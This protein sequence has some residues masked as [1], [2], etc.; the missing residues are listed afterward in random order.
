MDGKETG[1]K[2]LKNC[3]NDVVY[4]NPF[5]GIVNFCVFAKEGSPDGK[6]NLNPSCFNIVQDHP[7][8]SYGYSENIDL[9]NTPSTAK[10]WID[11]RELGDIRDEGKDKRTVNVYDNDRPN[12]I[13]RITNV[14]TGSQMFFPP[15]V[16]SSEAKI[17]NSSLY[18]TLNGRTNED[19]YKLFVENLG[20]DYNY[21]A[22]IAAP[23]FK[24]PY[25]VFSVDDKTIKTETEKENNY[26]YR[27]ILNNDLEFINFN[28]RVEDYFC[29]DTN[30]DGSKTYVHKPG[31]VGKRNGTFTKMVALWE[32]SGEFYIK[33]NVEYKLDVWVDDNVK[34]CNVEDCLKWTQHKAEVVSGAN[35]FHTGVKSGV[36][37]LDVPNDNDGESLSQEQK[38]DITKNINGDIYFTLKKSTPRVYDF[39]TPEEIEENHFPSISVELEDFSGLYRSLKLYFRVDDRN[40][41]VRV[42]EEKKKKKKK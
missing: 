12:I 4:F 10:E 38:V 8:I 17:S 24:P 20:P 37:R 9:G 19:E 22:I 2:Y 41:N 23:L 25:T 34:W 5:V 32:N 27:T 7:E 39:T 1:K 21:K 35:V 18:K 3:F 31:L 11:K 36:I 28:V 15:C 16:A 6:G 30:I 40:L 33:S 42:L 29:S 26:V 13:I 14:K